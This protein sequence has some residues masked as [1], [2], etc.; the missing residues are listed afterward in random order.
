MRRRDFLGSLGIAAISPRMAFAQ[1]R[2]PVVGFVGFATPEI[3]NATLIPFRKAMAGLG[4][5]EGRD[6]VID[7]RSTGGDVSRGLMLIDELVAKRVDVLLSPGPA[8]ARAIVKK[9]DIP[10]VAVA[11]P[12]VQSDPE[13]FQ[14]LARPGGSL[15][16]FAAFGEEMSAKRIEMI[17]E[18]VPTLKTIGV[19]NNATDPTFNA[20][21]AQTMLEARRAGVEPVQLGLTNASPAAVAEQFNLL[22]GAG[23][24][25]VIVIRDYM[26]AAMQNEICR[27][28]IE[29]KIAVIGQQ[30]EFA[31]AG[32]LFSYGAD[33]GD[34][35]RRAAAYVDLILKGQKPADMPIQLP[36]KFE[37]AVNLKTARV[38]GL[39]IPPTILVL[40]DE[41]IE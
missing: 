27:I 16:G 13:L 21:G 11:L 17:R 41:V 20:W 7:A 4:Y 36:T 22:S 3:D 6:V 30:S 37:L 5:V 14:S 10:V 9:T 34:L 26:T 40:A 2:V 28:G 18:I 31:R 24:S 19:L 29:T 35:F 12:A 32:A 8:A 25:A 39:T 23:G 15:T 1:R 33:I 38:L